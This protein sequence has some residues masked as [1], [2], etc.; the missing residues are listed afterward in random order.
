MNSPSQ[1]QIEITNN[2]S[3]IEIDSQTLLNIAQQVLSLQNMPN[4]EI[5]VV[6]VDNETIHNVN[7]EFL[8]HD[9]PTD[10][11]TFPMCELSEVSQL[12]PLEGEIVISAE[13]A[14]E[15]AQTVGW[16]T[17]DEIALYLIH[18]LLHLCGFDDLN[19]PDQLAMRQQEHAMLIATNMT[20]QPNDPRWQNLN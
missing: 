5:S 4:A 17:M 9:F 6:I 13:M 7:N 2:Q 11:I 20:P 8:Q 18:G 15:I 3:S 16:Q 10:V 12:Q 14:Q 1:Q 19:E